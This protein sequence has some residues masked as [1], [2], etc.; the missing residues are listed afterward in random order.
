MGK[1]LLYPT[2]KEISSIVCM[3][4]PKL[5]ATYVGRCGVLNSGKHLSTA[6]KVITYH[7]REDS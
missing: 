4:I 5:L 1:T 7:G 2:G 6:A 3:F